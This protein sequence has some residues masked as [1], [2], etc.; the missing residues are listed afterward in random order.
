MVTADS[1]TSEMKKKG[2]R[3]RK[4]TYARHGMAPEHTF[5]VS[6]D[7]KAIGPVGGKSFLL[8]HG[9]RVHRALGNG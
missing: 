5:G 7:R 1:I 3:R 2:K 8:A 4:K 6:I 9:C